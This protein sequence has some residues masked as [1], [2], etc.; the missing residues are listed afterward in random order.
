MKK[1]VV[2][3]L[4]VIFTASTAFA[5]CFW[6]RGIK[7]CPAPPSVRYYPQ[8]V[9]VAEPRVVVVREQ[10]PYPEPGSCLFGGIMGAIAAVVL[11]GRGHH[12]RGRR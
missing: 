5:D 4:L 2:V 10:E 1:I 9:Y 11:L 6:E 12:G 7:Y 3:V 8:P